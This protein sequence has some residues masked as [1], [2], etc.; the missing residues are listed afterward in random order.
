MKMLARNYVWWP[1]IDK[2]IENVAAECKVC[3]QER[4]KP[5]NVPLYPWPYPDHCWSRI[6]IDF[7]GPFHGHMFM[8]IIDAYSKWAEV[9]DMNKCTTVPR[10]IE[11]FKK[12]LVRFGLPKHLVTDNGTQ[13]TSKEFRDF[14]TS[15]G[16]KQSFTA[17]HHPATNG[18]AENFVGTF[19]NKVDKIMQNGKPLDYAVNLFLFDY[20]SIEHCTTGR[21][22]AFMM[23]KREI[24]T[25]FDL[26]KPS[27]T[28]HVGKRQLAQVENKHGNRNV[29]FHTG[30]TVMVDDFSVRSNKRVK[31]TIIEKLSPVTFKVEIAPDKI[32]KRHVDQIVRFRAATDDKGT[33]VSASKPDVVLRQSERLKE[34]K[35][36]VL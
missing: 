21:S 15:N 34:K 17:P 33:A 14:C 27:V 3:V 16:I 20:R 36:N 31:G 6:H 22:P 5:C 2:D 35:T 32:W 8:I 1:N 9:V 25:R 11:E 26:I 18:A 4:K 23:Y 29:E 19:K 30:D 12:V 24:R 28:D 13:F 10:V 7:L